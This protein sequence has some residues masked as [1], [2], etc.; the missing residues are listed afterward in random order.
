MLIYNVSSF[1]GNNATQYGTIYLGVDCNVFIERTNCSS[2][3][4]TFGGFLYGYRSSL[5]VS[6]STCTKN[7]SEKLGGCFY[8]KSSSAYFQNSTIFQNK[9]L[10]DGGGICATL[11]TVLHME[12]SLMFLNTANIGGAMRLMLDS[13]LFCYNCSIKNNTA[14]SGG[15]CYIEGNVE[16]NLLAQMAFSNVENN[17]ASDYGGTKA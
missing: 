13:R 6:R 10:E 12:D 7:V 8:L 9:A 3:N 16:Q 4:A 17:T 15:G 2:N 5:R 11:A 14:I 1:T